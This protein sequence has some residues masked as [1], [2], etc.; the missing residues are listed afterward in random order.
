MKNKEMQQIIARIHQ[1]LVKS[2]LVAESFL[3]T[4]FE[5]MLTDNNI[6]QLK[7]HFNVKVTNIM[8]YVEFSKK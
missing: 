5:F 4:D 2:S 1:A 6:K 7:E 3:N 8:G